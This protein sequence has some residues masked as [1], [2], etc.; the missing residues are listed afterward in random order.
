MFDLPPRLWISI[1]ALGGAGLTLPLAVTIAV[2]LALGYSLRRAAAWLTVLGTAIGAVAL[3]KIAFLGWGIG[4]R[5]WDF[6]GFSGHAMLSTSVYPVAM[7]L[8]LARARPAVRV[9]GVVVGLAAGVAVGL[10]RVAL[11]AHSPSEA[12]TGCVIGALAALSFIA[13]S[14]R[15]M[16]HRWSA[17]AVATSLVAVTIA[18]HGI[19]VPSHRWVT[20]VAL[21]LSGHE[22]PYVRARWKAN[23]NYRPASR[24]TQQQ[25]LG[26]P[27]AV[28]RA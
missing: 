24:P 8:A 12:V 21:Q 1:T 27:A 10:S 22:R 6:T 16:P 18:L 9:A 25:T 11:D 26:A 4:V 13:G 14:W 17:P 7:F 3:T 5:A 23:P 20:A 2:W 19:T 28:E 15:A